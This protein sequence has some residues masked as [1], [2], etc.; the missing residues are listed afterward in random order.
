[1]KSNVRIMLCTYPRP[2]ASVRQCSKVAISLWSNG[3]WN[4]L[5][6][7]TIYKKRYTKTFKTLS[8][9]HEY[10]DYTPRNMHMHVRAYP[11]DHYTN[12]IR[13]YHSG[14]GFTGLNPLHVPESI[15][16]H[17]GIL[18]TF[19]MPV[20]ELISTSA[21]SAEYIHLKYWNRNITKIK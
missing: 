19:P 2:P 15:H 1:M 16:G 4:V 14:T 13:C 7:P 11:G 8:A 6:S 5:P 9:S 18:K 10:I 21:I 3:E 20:N 17:W 12:M